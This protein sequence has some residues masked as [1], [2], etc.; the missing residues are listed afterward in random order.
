[1]ERAGL[2]FV[3]RIANDG[4]SG[5]EIKCLVTALATR[6]IEANANP[7]GPA[8]CLDFANELVPGHV[9]IIGRLRPLFKPRSILVEEGEVGKRGR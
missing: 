3:F 5:A 9:Y 4:K 1:M 6:R 2:Q 7:T 8:Y